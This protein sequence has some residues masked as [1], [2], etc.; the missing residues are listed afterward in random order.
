M[1]ISSTNKGIPKTFN[2]KVLNKLKATQTAYYKV[3]HQ[4]S[5]LTK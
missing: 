5:S 4:G 1:K 2:I 3:L